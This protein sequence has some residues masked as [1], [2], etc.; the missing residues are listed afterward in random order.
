MNKLQKVCVARGQLRFAV[1]CV[2]CCATVGKTHGPGPAVVVTSAKVSSSG[3]EFA[4]DG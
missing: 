2:S 4:V 3:S 1:K